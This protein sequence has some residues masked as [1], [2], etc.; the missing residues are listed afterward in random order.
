MGCITKLM[1]SVID[2]SILEW[3]LLTRKTELLSQSDFEVYLNYY[4]LYEY[5]DDICVL[6]DNPL[7]PGL[8]NYVKTGL[9]TKEEWIDA[10]K[11]D[12]DLEQ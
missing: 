10:L 4:R 11:Y 5:T 9:L 12:K 8:I 3:N 6:E 2:N 1:K 7:Y